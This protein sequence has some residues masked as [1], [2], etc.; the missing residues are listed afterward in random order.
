MKI[1]YT[2]LI[3][4]LLLMM[5]LPVE[6]QITL[7][8][9]IQHDNTTRNYRLY[10][11][12]GYTNEA[13]M[14]LVLNLHGFGS[15]S[16]EQQVYS[17]MFTIADTAGFAI[18]Y[19]D[20]LLR[21]WNVGWDFG[22]MA[23]DVGFLSALIDSLLAEYSLDAD[24]VYACGMSNGGFMSYS[25]A[26]E[27]ND[28]V[29]AVASVTGAFSPTYAP[30]C[31]PGR[32]VPVMQIHGTADTVIR[33]NGTPDV[34]IP[35]EEVVDFWV[36][37]NGCDTNP[38]ITPVPDI[39]M[40]D[41]STA[42]RLDYPNCRDGSAVAFYRIEGGGHTWP[43]SFIIFDIT[44]QDFEASEV[45]WNFFQQFRLDDV[46][47]VEQPSVALSLKTFPNPA[48]D[49]LYLD[50]PLEWIG[51]MYELR[52]M[53]GQRVLTGRISTSPQAVS[54]SSLPAGLYAL[55]LQT[56]DGQRVSRKVLRR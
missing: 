14:P 35:I 20:G 54:L 34:S 11:P 19:P 16:F 30:T 27:L 51:S 6:G 38:V 55:A 12:P 33:Y 53:T 29:A 32:A 48:G 45:I 3:S 13:N 24:R 25:L 28:K 31:E 37:N 1:I 46:V 7:Q 42:E 39:N 40:T 23:D 52:N 44:N 15:E 50:A 22:S 10:L 47:S 2:I 49:L 5:G 43:G 17:E 4:V 21:S 56:P 18:C 26:C 41:G 8:G 36:M 9:S